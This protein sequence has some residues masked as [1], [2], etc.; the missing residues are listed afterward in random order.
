MLWAIA[1]KWRQAW[2]NKSGRDY[3]ARLRLW[4]DF[5]EEY[6]AQPDN[7]IDRYPYEVG[8]RVQLELLAN[9]LDEIP[10]AEHEL[11][12]GLDKVLGTVFVP[13]GFVWEA[14]L[15]SGFPNPPFWYLFGR[16]GER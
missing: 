12:A 4:R 6:R 14:D 15:A 8:R 13:G 1:A 11:L 16:V 10:A 9:Q 2:Q 5:L 7:H 3:S